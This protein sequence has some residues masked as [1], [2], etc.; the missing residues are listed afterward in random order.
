MLNTLRYV[1]VV[2]VVT[3]NL[4]VA[5]YLSVFAWLSSNWMT[6]R[7]A[8]YWG[9]YHWLCAAF[10]R[11]LYWLVIAL[12]VGG[13]CGVVNW[14][15]MNRLLPKRK[16]LPWFLGG[17]VCLAIAFGGLVGSVFFYVEKPWM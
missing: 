16:S 15:A 7:Q 1:C 10:E 17:S 5:G 14:F 9:S 8:R 2:F 4:A 11:A 12:V 3:V 13:L 6:G